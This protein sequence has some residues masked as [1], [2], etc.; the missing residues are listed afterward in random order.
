MGREERKAKVRF[1][2]PLSSTQTPFLID[3]TPCSA[4]YQGKEGS[5]LQ[6]RKGSFGL[7]EFPL[8]V[9]GH[10]AHSKTGASSS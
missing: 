7:F 5:V 4:A 10:R 2:F 9:R 8:F 6:V 3:W 1:I